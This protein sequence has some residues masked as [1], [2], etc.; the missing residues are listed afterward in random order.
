MGAG[1]VQVLIFQSSAA[2]RRRRV[3]QGIIQFV[4]RME[5]FVLMI[6][7]GSIVSPVR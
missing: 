2:R 3:D 6:M 7:L 4:A 1:R 5:I